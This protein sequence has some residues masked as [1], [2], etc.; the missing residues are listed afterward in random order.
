MSTL[1]AI[2]PVNAHETTELHSTIIHVDESGYSPAIT[3]IDPGT[4][5]IFENVGEEK[6]WP[7]TDDHPSHTRYDGTSLEEHCH[8]TETA[9]FDSCVGIEPGKTWSFTFDN[10]GTFS[11]HD[12]LWPHLT[13][14]IRVEKK[15]AIP[16]Q[17]NL[18]ERI[19]NFIR[20]I[21][22]KNTSPKT[23]EIITTSDSFY[24]Q[25]KS[26]YIQLVQDENPSI[27]IQQLRDESAQNPKVLSLC[28]DVLHEIGHTAYEKYGSF[29]EAVIYQNDFCNSGYIH[30]LF[31]SYF[32]TAENPLEGI[33]QQCATYNTG[34][35]KIDIWQC[36]HGIGHGFMYLTGGHLP[37]S[38]QLCQEELSGEA[39]TSCQNGVYMEVFNTEVLAKE[40]E[41]IDPDNPF[42]TCQNQKIAKSECYVYVPAYFSQVQNMSFSEILRTCLATEPT[43][44]DN[45][46]FGVGTEAIKRNMHDPQKV[47]DICLQASTP[48]HKQN[49]IH[50]M[51]VM[52]MNQ[53]G[54]PDTVHEMCQQAPK[55]YQKFCKRTAEG[56]RDFFE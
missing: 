47:F 27:A 55:E 29:S 22:Y 1:L 23:Q 54:N 15:E 51:V 41:F 14:K 30:G 44:V 40:A 8:D 33:S 10:P 43:Y 25:L 37:E 36:H 31:E 42:L 3:I 13:G 11:Y 34:G 39:S 26:D 49:C 5:V 2:S 19:M 24:T 35:R 4:T 21:F 38:L 20:R 45:C 7:A 48:A 6:H 9:T 50:G 32:A 52:Y 18:V 46:V 12:H 28:H 56:Q 16:T 17:P 53:E